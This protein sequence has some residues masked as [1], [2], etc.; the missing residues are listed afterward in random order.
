MLPQQLELSGC[1]NLGQQKHLTIL[2]QSETQDFGS[3]G[4]IGLQGP[5]SQRHRERVL[6]ASPASGVSRR[7]TAPGLYLNHCQL[8]CCHAFLLCLHIVSFLFNFLLSKRQSLWIKY[9]ATS[10]QF[11]VS[12]KTRASHKVTLRA[13]GYLSGFSH[14]DKMPERNL[15][16][17]A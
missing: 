14:C 17:A 9:P 1:L 11:L 2:G 10:F 8:F 7:A 12:S 6:L 4:T 16:E 5:V 13:S 3:I 15:A